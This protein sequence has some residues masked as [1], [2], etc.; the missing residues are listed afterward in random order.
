MPLAEMPQDL[1]LMLVTGS[2]AIWPGPMDRSKDKLRQEKPATSCPQLLR[3][4]VSFLVPVGVTPQTS[5]PGVPP[6]FSLGPF[7]GYK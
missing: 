5:K 3:A 7:F 6:A 2:G 1:A 4:F